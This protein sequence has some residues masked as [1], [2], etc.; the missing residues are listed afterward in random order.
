MQKWLAI[1]T[2]PMFALG[3]MAA[4][5]L[6][7]VP[8]PPAATRPISYSKDIHVIL[9]EHCAQCHLDGKRKGGLQLDSREAI[10]KGG[11]DGAAVVVGKSAESLLVK[12]VAGADPE[13]VMPKKGDRLSVE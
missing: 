5:Q 4:D 6:Q 3:A 12:L 11:D 13:R 9:A 8:L 1:A 2:L 7:D 10:L